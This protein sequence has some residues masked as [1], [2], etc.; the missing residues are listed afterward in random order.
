MSNWFNEPK[1]TEAAAILL[2]L[3]Q[4]R[5]NIVKLLKLLY[6]ADREALERFERPITNDSYCSMDQG[7]VLRTTYNIIQNRAYGRGDYW[8]ESIS[9][10]DPFHKVAL[11]SN[12]K[13]KKLSPAEVEVLHDIYEEFGP[14]D[15][16]TLVEMTHD[17]PEYKDPSGSSIPIELHEILDPLGY[18]V[19]DI[20]RIKAELEAEAETD[21]ILSG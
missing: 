19:N 10:R 12:V 3:N 4:G 18:S 13:P 8:G 1:A 16:W 21:K 5:M 7:P 6:L 14:Y 17:L 11:L 9:Q 15:T 20:D 2:K